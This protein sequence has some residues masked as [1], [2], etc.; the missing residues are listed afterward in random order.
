M[1]TKANSPLV[2]I[3]VHAPPIGGCDKKS[4]INKKHSVCVEVQTAAGFLSLFRSPNNLHIHI[5]RHTRVCVYKCWDNFGQQFY[6][7]RGHP[8]PPA[9]CQQHLERAGGCHN[10]SRAHSTAAS[11]LWPHPTGNSTRI[12]LEIDS[13]TVKAAHEKRDRI[14]TLNIKIP[15]ILCSK[16][17]RKECNAEARLTIL[18]FVGVHSVHGKTTHD[19][20]RFWLAKITPRKSPKT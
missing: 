18:F 4:F 9:Y 12:H 19:L 8:F 14:C 11:P 7:V 16:L 15:R 1:T 3:K 2:E 5:Y 10:L 13:A 6:K 20:V 17:A